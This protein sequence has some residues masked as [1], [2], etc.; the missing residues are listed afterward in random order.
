MYF[1]SESNECRNVSPVAGRSL[2]SFK[3]RAAFWLHASKIISPWLSLQKSPPEKNLRDP[4]FQS[5]RSSVRKSSD[6]PKEKNLQTFRR[7]YLVAGLIPPSHGG[8][9]RRPP[10]WCVFGRSNIGKVMQKPFFGGAAF[11]DGRIGW[12]RDALVLGLRGW[13]LWMSHFKSL[14]RPSCTG[15]V[16]MVSPSK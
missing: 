11:S 16:G 6:P 8:W 5:P 15:H 7:N 13:N 1:S 12:K 2:A 3:S 9:A 10:H 14:S 4:K